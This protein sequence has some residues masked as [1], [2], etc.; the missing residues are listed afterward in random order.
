[1]KKELPSIQPQ[2]AKRLVL[3]LLCN[4]VRVLEASATS[5]TGHSYYSSTVV[6]LLG[7]DRAAS[8]PLPLLRQTGMGELGLQHRRVI[9]AKHSGYRRPT[10]LQYRRRSSQSN[11]ESAL[12]IPCNPLGLDTATL[13]VNQLRG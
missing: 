9:D 2:L 1:M 6:R 10:N 13:T 4:I 5:S 8:F 7:D 12:E 11:G 3:A